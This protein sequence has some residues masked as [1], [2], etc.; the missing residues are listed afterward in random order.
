MAKAE[1]RTSSSHLLPLPS[2]FSSTISST[3]TSHFQLNSE[4]ESE[5]I[6]SDGPV[7]HTEPATY[8]PQGNDESDV[9]DSPFSS[10][11][12][13]KPTQHPLE[14][15]GRVRVQTGGGN[16][17]D[18]DEDRDGGGGVRKPYVRT[19]SKTPR[20]TSSRS[21]SRGPTKN[22][23][24]PHQST[25]APSFQTSLPIN[26]ESEDPTTS[27]STSEID[28]DARAARAYVA[29]NSGSDTD[30]GLGAPVAVGGREGGRSE[31]RGEK[32]GGGEGGSRSRSRG[33]VPR[34]DVELNSASDSDFVEGEGRAG[35]EQREEQ[36]GAGGGGKRERIGIALNSESEM[37]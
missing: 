31:G 18:Q 35:R 34:Y 33:R 23:T 4:S 12:A 20:G 21:R 25:A 3:M 6:T 16:D 9:S 26:S 37:E 36:A 24:D 13:L 28:E 1:W 32:V 30:G 29:Q 10:A 19:R 15:R 5:A 14:Q 2:S 11:T 27:A 22:G 7:S 8:I 17:S